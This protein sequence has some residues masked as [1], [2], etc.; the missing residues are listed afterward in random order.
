M[1]E[2]KDKGSTLI[3]RMKFNC[4]KMK[5]QGRELAGRR[6]RDKTRMEGEW[7]GEDG[8]RQMIKTRNMGTEINGESKQL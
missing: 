5:K 7:E 2:Y 8:I 3:G 1:N 4:K 6:G